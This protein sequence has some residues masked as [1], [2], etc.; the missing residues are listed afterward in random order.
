MKTCVNCGNKSPKDAKVCNVCKSEFSNQSTN[1]ELP[2]GAIILIIFIV[3]LI[4]LGVFAAI[5]VPLFN[6]YYGSKAN[7]K[8]E[9]ENNLIQECDNIK[10]TI[11]FRDSKDNLLMDNDVLK[12]GGAKMGQDEN[13]RPTITLSIADKDKFYEVTNRISQ[14]EDNL[15]VIWLDYDGSTSF[16]K[17]RESCGNGESKCLS[18]ATVSQGFASDVIIPGSFGEGELEE[19]VYKINCSSLVD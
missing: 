7:L 8:N 6:T 11:S 3:V 19:I 13:G 12:A 15:I 18:A 9:V 2:I 4:I 10:H 16:E 17:E 1:N 14:Q 5:F